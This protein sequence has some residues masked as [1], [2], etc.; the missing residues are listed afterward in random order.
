[1]SNYRA[2]FNRGTAVFDA[3]FGYQISDA[4][5]VNF[6]ANNV[7]NTEYVSR[8]GTVQAPRNF[9]FQMQLSL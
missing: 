8:P 4:V 5:K 7:F 1:M 3:R 2:K 9:L 6:I